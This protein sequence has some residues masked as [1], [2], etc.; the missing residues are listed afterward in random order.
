[1]LQDVESLV[2]KGTSISNNFSV[3]PVY[4]YSPVLTFTGGYSQSFTNGNGAVDYTHTIGARAVYNWRQEHNLFGGYTLNIFDWHPFSG[5]SKTTYVHNVDIGDDFFSNLKI[6]LTP[7]LTL[8]GAFGLAYKSEGPGPKIVPSLNAVLSK[9]W[10]N[11]IFNFAIRRGVTTSVG[12]FSGPS[13]TTTFSAGYGIRLTERLTALAG[14][15]YS[16][17]GQ[18][19]EAD[20]EI[21]RGSAGLQ[22]WL[23]SWLSSNLWYSRRWRSAVASAV[24]VPSGTAR[25]NSVIASITAHFDVY[26]NPGMARGGIDRPLFAPIGSPSYERTEMQQ[27]LRPG[28]AR[29]DVQQQLQ[30]PLREQPARPTPPPAPPKPEETK[31]QDSETTPAR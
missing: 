29:P 31:P 20:I 8:S 4:L 26:P 19:H 12:L 22:Y 25:G 21:F 23:T 15:D 5:K 30:Q 14:A 24:D 16:L 13:T 11:A 9:V 10:Q 18:G 28:S 1:L 3:Q 17:L 6:K 27:P 7:T 2:S